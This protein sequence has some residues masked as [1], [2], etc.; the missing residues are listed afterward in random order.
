MQSSL[1]KSVTIKKQ[2]P[3]DSLRGERQ[4]IVSVEFQPQ[5]LSV[6]LTNEHYWHMRQGGPDQAYIDKHNAIQAAGMLSDRVT[7]ELREDL[8]RLLPVCVE[9]RTLIERR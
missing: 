8:M 3:F 2:S 4:V 9:G 5:V 6:A 7:G 1:I